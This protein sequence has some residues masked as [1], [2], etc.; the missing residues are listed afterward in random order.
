MHYKNCASSVVLKICNEF[1]K[2][3]GVQEKFTNNMFLFDKTEIMLENISFYLKEKFNEYQ[4]T[5]ETKRDAFTPK[6]I[7]CIYNQVSNIQ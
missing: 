1:L 7:R 5:A 3:E 6:S 4:Q 2:C